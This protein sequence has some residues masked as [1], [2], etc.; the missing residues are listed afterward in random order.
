MR[1]APLLVPLLLLLPLAGAAGTA[2]SGVTHFR[3]EAPATFAGPIVVG[4]TFDF[5]PTN[6]CVF[7]TWASGL[8]SSLPILTW[9]E[10]NGNGAAFFST[11]TAQAHTD[12]TGERI[13]TREM[14]RSGGLWSLKSTTTGPFSGV[15]DYV[16]IVVESGA[17]ANAATGYHPP[18]VIDVTCDNAFAVG[19]FGFGT[20]AKGFTADSMKGGTGASGNQLFGSANVAM[21]DSVEADF[22]AEN[23][24]FRARARSG[25]SLVAG[26]MR[27]AEPTG[28]HAWP[29]TG[30]ENLA[31]ESGPGA[32]R[33][34][35]DYRAVGL[36]DRITGIL[37]GY[38]AVPAL[39]Y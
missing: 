33:V 12:A 26:E 20:E 23:V 39:P 16:H 6:R 3:F 38:D 22:D 10:R 8:R 36:Y 30:N 17:W 31:L 2:D 19:D 29:I 35:L 25:N 18:L 28:A 11:Y 1:A 15:L 9:E 4:A 27:L 21:G 5:G 13:D 34:E 32:Y 14:I 24:A 7:M 37:Y